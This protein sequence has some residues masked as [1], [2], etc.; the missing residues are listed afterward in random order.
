MLASPPTP[1]EKA[2]V[3]RQG[4]VK[5]FN[6]SSGLGCIRVDGGDEIAV[7]ASAIVGAG[8]LRVLEEGQ[9]V[10][11]DIAQGPRGPQ[12]EKVVPVGETPE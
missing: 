5:W 1:Q 6:T 8:G 2:F 11:F 4:L 10:E 7:H 12:A 9:A 3:R